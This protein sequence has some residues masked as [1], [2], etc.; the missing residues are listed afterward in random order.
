MTKE[1][2]LP[3]VPAHGKNLNLLIGDT[4]E[5]YSAELSRKVAGGAKARDVKNEI[6]TRVMRVDE[7]YGSVKRKIEKRRN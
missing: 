3:L 4:C 2:Q 7:H 5:F 1:L 6:Q